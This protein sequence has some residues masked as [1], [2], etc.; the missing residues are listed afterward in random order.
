MSPADDFFDLGGHSLRAIT[1]MFSINR[2]FG[3]KLP[4]SSVFTAR[5]VAAMAGLVR[6]SSPQDSN[7][8]PLGNGQGGAPIFCI[9]PSGGSTLSYWEL[10]RLLPPDRQILGVESRGLHGG[11][12][13]QQFT[14][15]AE[16]YAASIAG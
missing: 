15:M 6:N 11:P 7:L 16:D 2:A 10:A 1:L 4:M 5:S 9:H 3:C 13:Q 8:V 14:E 12:P